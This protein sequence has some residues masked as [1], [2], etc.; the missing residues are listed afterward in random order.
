MS[1]F[2]KAKVIILPTTNDSNIY[3]KPQNGHL[4]IITDIKAKKICYIT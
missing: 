2:K 3:L 4:V 1:T